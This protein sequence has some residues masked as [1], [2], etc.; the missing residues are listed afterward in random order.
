MKKLNR[1][2]DKTYK[3][4]LSDVKPAGVDNKVV[5]LNVKTT[6]PLLEYLIKNVKQS[7]NN[8]KALLKNKKILVDGAVVTQFDYMLRPKQVVAIS[9]Y[10][11]MQKSLKSSLDI[12]YEDDDLIVINK[13]AGLLSVA[14]DKQ[15]TETAYRMVMD[16]VRT[17][18]RKGELFITHR[19]DRDTSGLLIFTKNYQLR[20]ALQDDWNKLVK[21]RGY[22]AL[23]SGNLKKKQDTLINYLK[24][25]ELHMIYISNSKHDAQEAITH[26]Q[27]VKE[28]KTYSL[29][30]IKIDTGRKNQIRVQLNHIGHPVVGDNKYGPKDSPFKRLMLHAYKLEFTHPFTK[31]NFKFETKIPPIFTKLF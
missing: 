14:T 15:I 21:V 2:R 8:I 22:Y 17:D 16:Y 4:P 31:K 20:E 9:K 27:V 10:P 30:D 3:N 18:H 13:P 23:V 29:L 7:R 25:N 1:G 26:Y 6:S 11:M 19:L 5:E 28:S 12:I 24:E